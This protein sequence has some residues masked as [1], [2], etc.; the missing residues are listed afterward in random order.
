MKAVPDSKSLQTVRIP[1]VWRSELGGVLLFLVF[2]ALSLF[3]TKLFPWSVLDGSIFESDAFTIRLKLPLFWLLPTFN[4]GV[5]LFRMYDV[6]YLATAEGLEISVGQVSLQQMVTKIRYEDIR[7]IEVIQSLF[8]R[9]LDIGIIEIGTAASGG[10]DV[11][12]EGIAAPRDVQDALI[13]ERDRRRQIALSQAMK[14]EVR[15]VSNFS[16]TQE[17]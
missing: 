9:L 7:G 1:K 3:L 10:I 16:L 11:I 13:G 4:L 8:E 15:V 6:K 14:E 12:M 5:L 17:R 2:C